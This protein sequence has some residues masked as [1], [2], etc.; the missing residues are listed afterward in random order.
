MVLKPPVR[1]EWNRLHARLLSMQN[2][3]KVSKTLV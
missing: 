2:V 1:P 3:M